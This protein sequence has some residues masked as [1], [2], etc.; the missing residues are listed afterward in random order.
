MRMQILLIFALA[1]VRRFLELTEPHNKIDATVGYEKQ[2]RGVQEQN[3][4]V[5]NLPELT[6]ITTLI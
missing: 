6:F 4:K 1:T 2:S 3:Y 5:D